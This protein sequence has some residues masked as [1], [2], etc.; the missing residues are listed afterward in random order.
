MLVLILR[1]LLHVNV[2]TLTTVGLQ[3]RS[4][5]FAYSYPMANSDSS[6][7]FRIP[8]TTQNDSSGEFCIPDYGNEVLTSRMIISMP[9]VK[10]TVHRRGARAFGT[11]LQEIS[12]NVR[13]KLSRVCACSKKKESCWIRL[14]DA[15][16]RILQRT[17]AFSAYTMEEKRTRIYHEL[18]GMYEQN[19]GTTR[20]VFNYR[21]VTDLPFNS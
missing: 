2:E 17:K 3:R 21:Y 4:D 10:P 9:D 19:T 1:L 16:E 13:D 6:G 7:S 18:C 12:V 20:G 8:F 14:N 15:P 5:L 11:S